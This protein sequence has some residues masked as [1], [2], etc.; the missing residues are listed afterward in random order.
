MKINK[1]LFADMDDIK[2]GFQGKNAQLEHFDNDKEDKKYKLFIANQKKPQS[3][4]QEK[5]EKQKRIE[6]LKRETQQ[7]EQK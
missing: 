5:T 4:M 7:L 1:H 6:E 3:Q 2:Y